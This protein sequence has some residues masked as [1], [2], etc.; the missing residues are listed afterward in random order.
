M[1][2]AG[3]N[4]RRVYHTTNTVVSRTEDHP[5]PEDAT[6]ATIPTKLSPEE[7]RGEE[8]CAMPR[9]NSSIVN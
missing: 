4:I 1:R 3:S 8:Q 2:S 6:H 5:L 7:V 9:R